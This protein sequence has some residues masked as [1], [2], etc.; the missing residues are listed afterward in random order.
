M[1]GVGGR[2]LVVEWHEDAEQL[3]QRYRQE[4]VA[5]VRTRLPALWLVRAGQSLRA[6]ART[7][8]VDEATVS[9][10]ISWYRRGGVG[11]VQRHRPGGGPGRAACL[12]GEQQEALKAQARARA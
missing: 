6:A 9:Q 8:G 10:W 11:E 5:A 7:L 1:A 3:R 4:R 2:P 12:T